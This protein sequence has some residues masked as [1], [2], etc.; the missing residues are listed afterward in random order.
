MSGANRAKRLVKRNQ[1]LL[2][3]AQRLRRTF[4]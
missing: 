1:T 2:G 4:G 3:L